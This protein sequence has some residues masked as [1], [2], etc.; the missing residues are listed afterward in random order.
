MER[1]LVPVRFFTDCRNFARYVECL[2]AGANYFNLYFSEYRILFGRDQVLIRMVT[3]KIDLLCSEC[4]VLFLIKRVIP[5]THAVN[6]FAAKT[7]FKP[8]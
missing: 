4:L 7:A 1:K 2:R 8:I 5:A 6:H 3:L